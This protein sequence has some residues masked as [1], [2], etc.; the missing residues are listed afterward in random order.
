MFNADIVPLSTT[1]GVFSVYHFGNAFLLLL[2]LGAVVLFWNGPLVLYRYW[3]LATQQ[4]KDLVMDHSKV[5]LQRRTMSFVVVV[6][7][8]V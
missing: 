4:S 5:L 7:C 6:H 8:G 2:V 3:C 1:P